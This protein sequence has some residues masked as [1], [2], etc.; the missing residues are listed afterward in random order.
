MSSDEALRRAISAHLRR[1]L[2]PPGE[3]F[4][5]AARSAARGAR[6]TRVDMPYFLPEQHVEHAVL[7]TIG[8]SAYVMPDGGRVEGLL[9]FAEPPARAELDA[10]QALLLAFATYAEAHRTSLDLGD[11]VPVGEMLRPLGPMTSL[12]LL[13]PVPVGRA[14]GTLT[15]DDATRVDLVWL[16]PLY[17][18]EAKR[19]LADGAEALMGLFAIE[20]VDP[21]DWRRRP[22]DATRPV[23]DLPAIRAILKARDGRATRAASYT[24]S[25]KGDVIEITRRGGRGRS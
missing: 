24:S 22:V 23:P 1:H 2:G 11:V 25:V 4:S 14:L 20:D 6:V 18:A 7:A 13:P 12:V 19:A 5:H 17:D 16:L 10:L 8:A 15:L 3:T 21:T 9:V